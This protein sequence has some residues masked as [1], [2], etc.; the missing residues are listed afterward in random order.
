[1]EAM[2]PTQKPWGIKHQCAYFLHSE[3]SLR[4][5]EVDKAKGKNF[6][7][8]KSSLAMCDVYVEGNMANIPQ[9]IRINISSKPKIIQNL[10][11]K[12]DYKPE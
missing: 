5:I 1:M 10:F 7:W 8:Y 6:H 9:T 11:I 12:G 4:S 3:I 2:N